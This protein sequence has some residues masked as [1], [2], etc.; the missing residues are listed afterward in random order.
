MSHMI[1]IN[2]SVLSSQ[3]AYVNSFI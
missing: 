1:M 2:A 3:S